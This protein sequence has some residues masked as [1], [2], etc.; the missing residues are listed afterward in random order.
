[1]AFSVILN[2][3]KENGVIVIDACLVSIAVI[4]TYELN[5][6]NWNEILGQYI[7]LFKII[8]KLEFNLFKFEFI[9]NF[10]CKISFKYIKFLFSYYFKKR[11]RIITKHPLYPNVKRIVSI[12]Q[13]LY[14]YIL[15]QL[16]KYFFFILVIF[17]LKIITIIY[18]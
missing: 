17:L 3:E 10:I 9:N 1:M 12:Q 6:L 11:V 18:K 4:L 8:I 13:I 7:T 14:Q 5:Y 16:C 15:F 2:K